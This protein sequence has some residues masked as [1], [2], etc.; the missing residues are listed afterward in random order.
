MD[1]ALESE[2]ETETGQKDQIDAKDA[3]KEKA[4]NRRE[5]ELS[6]LQENLAEL[7]L[8]E[9]KFMSV[10][11]CEKGNEYFKA[12]ENDEAISCYSKSIILDASNVKSYTNRAA[13]SICQSN[14][15]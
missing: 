1:A 4:S 7:T 15:D 5:N 14:F 3:E 6:E 2:D 11:E 9:R 12:G 13:A 10:R 8:A